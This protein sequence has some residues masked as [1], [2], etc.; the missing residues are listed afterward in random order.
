MLQKKINEHEVSQN[1][2]QLIFNLDINA[3][4]KMSAMLIIATVIKLSSREKSKAEQ[5]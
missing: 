2:K 3:K 5:I 1:A 4:P